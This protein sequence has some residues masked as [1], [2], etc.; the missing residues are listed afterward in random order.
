MWAIQLWGSLWRNSI[1]GQIFCPIRF[2][3][4][5]NTI[6]SPP[7]K[8]SYFNCIQ[9]KLV[10]TT[11]ILSTVIEPSGI[12]EVPF[13]MNHFSPWWPF[14]HILSISQH[15]TAFCGYELNTTCLPQ[16]WMRIDAWIHCVFDTYVQNHT[17]CRMVPHGQWPYSEQ[18]MTLNSSSD[19]PKKHSAESAVW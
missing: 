10:N 7:L 8:Q 4:I 5:N 11:S 2:C 19:T 15:R 9:S 13:L 1:S 6:K 3:L 18:H 17:C 12:P 14:W 16:T